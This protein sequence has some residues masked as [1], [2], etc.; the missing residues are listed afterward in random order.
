MILLH[1]PS[2][3]GYPQLWKPPKGCSLS[4]RIL[5]ILLPEL[6]FKVEFLVRPGVPNHMAD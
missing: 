2:I 4:R 5:F 6:R 1:E 3:L